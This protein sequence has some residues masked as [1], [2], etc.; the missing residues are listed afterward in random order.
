MMQRYFRVWTRLTRMAFS[1]TASNRI[2]GLSYFLG[3]CI[4]FVFF[5]LFISAIFQNTPT[6]AGYTSYEILF[7]FLTY[8]LLDVAAQMF[9]RGVYSFRNSVRLGTFDFTLIKPINSLFY[10]LTQ[11]TDLLDTLFLI[12]ILGM[13]LYI[14][15]KLPID[16]FFSS[17]GEYVLLLSCSMIILLSFHIITAALT[18]RYVDADQGIWLYRELMAIGRFPPDILPSPLQFLCTFILPIIVVVSFP[19]KAVI[20]ELSVFWWGVAFLVTSFFFLFSIFLWCH[21]L[22]AYSSASS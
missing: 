14:F 6:F 9:F 18:V 22:R 7:F 13:I 1:V 20:G 17:V 21:N 5:I 10:S 12:P 19:A 2:D 16:S 15:P 11:L 3:K 8:N 4:R